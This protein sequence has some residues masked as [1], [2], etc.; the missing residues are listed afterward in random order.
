MLNRDSFEMLDMSQYR[1]TGEGANGSSY[2]SLLDPDYMVKMYNVGYPEGAV[3]EE[4]GVAAKVYGL[5][6]ASPEPGCLVTDGE[7]LGIRFR[8]IRGKR[9]YARMIA[10]EPER[11]EDFTREFARQ[12]KV[13]HAVKCPDNLFTDV[14]RQS[15]N[16]L[17]KNNLEPELKRRIKRFIESAPDAD[18]ALHGDM[19]IGNAIS[20]L[21]AG[22]LLSAPHDIYFIDLGMFAH[23]F[24]LFDLGMMQNICLYSDESFRREAFHVTGEVTREVWRI[25]VDEYF[26]AEDRLADK[27]IG[28]GQTPESVDRAIMP[29]QCCKLLLV[30]Y[31]LGFM[32]P[33]YLKF[34]EDTFY[35]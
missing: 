27:L 9:S 28:P 5:G 8:R 18:T 32:P 12:C 30:G 1:Q 4:V 22:A 11:L 15:L 19:H 24:P 23:G 35:L 33:H 25:F 2:D 14:R 16:L 34:I 13:L 7:R 3:E 26:F 17:S 29:Y 10:D 6:I 21:P 20:T 31:N